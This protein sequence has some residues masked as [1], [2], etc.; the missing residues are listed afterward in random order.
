[1]QA[2]KRTLGVFKPRDCLQI[3][4][5]ELLGHICHA[6]DLKGKVGLPCRVSLE[7]RA[8]VALLSADLFPL[9]LSSLTG[10]RTEKTTGAVTVLYTMA[11]VLETEARPLNLSCCVG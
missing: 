10:A 8:M 9:I 6:E 2:I 11:N 4:A 3:S 1:M 7:Q 5:L